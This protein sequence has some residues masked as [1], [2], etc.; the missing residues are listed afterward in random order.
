MDISY[1]HSNRYYITKRKRD[2]H[3]ESETA[4]SDNL[5]AS[6]AVATIGAWGVNPPP[7]QS[8]LP[9]PNFW[10]IITMTIFL[11]RFS[12]N[13]TKF[14]KFVVKISGAKPPNPHLFINN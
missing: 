7:H 1:I 14:K 12:R 4:E 8:V 11:W 9:P 10:E 6:R 5:S 13:F 3:F 2:E